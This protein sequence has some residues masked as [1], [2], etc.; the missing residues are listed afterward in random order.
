LTSNSWHQQSVMQGVILYLGRWCSSDTH[1]R[2]VMSFRS[3]MSA[4]PS[5]VSRAFIQLR[6]AR[7]LELRTFPC[8]PA[9][10][11]HMDCHHTGDR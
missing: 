6:L 4:I 2:M 8:S 10:S 5:A 3:G 1:W 11:T 7:P 9:L